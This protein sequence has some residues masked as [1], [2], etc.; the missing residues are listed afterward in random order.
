MIISNYSTQNIQQLKHSVI[1]EQQVLILDGLS[2]I[3]SGLSQTLQQFVSEGGSLLI[4]PAEKSDLTNYQKLLQSLGTNYF[5]FLDE[6][7]INIKQ[8]HKQHSIFMVFLKK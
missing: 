2:Y 7:I 5:L 1:L 6:S 3:S 4:F 8:L